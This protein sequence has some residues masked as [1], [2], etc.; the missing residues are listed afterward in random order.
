MSG[1]ISLPYDEPAC[2]A[3]AEHIARRIVR[4]LVQKYW[5]AASLRVSTKENE[6]VVTEADHAIEEEI[7]SYL[8]HAF[9]GYGLI[10]EELG[11]QDAESASTSGRSTR[12]TAQTRSSRDCRCSERSWRSSARRLMRACP[13]SGRSI[14]RCRINS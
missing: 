11:A 3:A 10:G 2:R 6:S 5:Q 9:P 13:Y 4:P 7:R 14:F 8:G 12:S 1:A